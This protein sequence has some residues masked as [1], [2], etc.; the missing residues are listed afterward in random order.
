MHVCNTGDEMWTRE[1]SKVFPNIKKLDIWRIWTDINNWPAWH[2]DLDYCKMEGE[3]KEGNYF[4]LKPKGHMPV[5]IILTEIKVDNYFT[6][7]TKFPGAR[8]YNTHVI[9]ETIE[10]LRLKNK[11]M[12][13]G[14]LKWLW[15]ILV[16][17]N[18]AKTIPEEIEALVKLARKQNG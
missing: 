8:M 7:C 6:D 10:G 18:V 5:K 1:Y 17:K 9:E 2:G 12:V 3:F 13:T 11:L 16:A 15:I 14:P 4:F